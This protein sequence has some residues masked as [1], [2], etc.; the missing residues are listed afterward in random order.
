MT[1]ANP[2]AAKTCAGRNSHLII[3]MLLLH[4]GM[5]H[6][7]LASIQ[8]QVRKSPS[9]QTVLFWVSCDCYAKRMSIRRECGKHDGQTRRADATAILTQSVSTI[10]ESQQRPAHKP[11]GKLSSRLPAENL[12]EHGARH[13]DDSTQSNIR[14]DQ[15]FDVGQEGADGSEE[16][17]NFGFEVDGLSLSRD[18]LIT[19]CPPTPT[20]DSDVHLPTN[21]L[22]EYVIGLVTTSEYRLLY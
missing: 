20:S 3:C 13:K 12:K 22:L 19:R 11:R 2:S 5:S 4:R 18:P 9:P 10:A 17:D 6:A 8:K 7:P 21:N 15:G 16:C 14:V 1:G